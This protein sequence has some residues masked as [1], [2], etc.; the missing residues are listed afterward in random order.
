MKSI[1]MCC[2][3]N[4]SLTASMRKKNASLLRRVLDNCK[5]SQFGGSDLCD[6]LDNLPHIRSAFPQILGLRDLNELLRRIVSKEVLERSTLENRRAAELAQVFTPTSAYNNALVS[7]QRH[8]FVVLTG[9]P[10][11]GKTIIARIIG[12]AKLAEC[13]EC[14]ECRKPNDL[15]HMFNRSARQVFIAD[16]AFGSTEYRPDLALPWAD[17]LDRILRLLDEDHWLLWTSRPAPLHIALRHI[18]LKEL[19]GSF[20]D[21]G[22]V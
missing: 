13:W 2:L 21:P 7:L 20:P 5:I 1:T 15:F 10:E 22:E 8:H 6:Y 18:E 12:L 19:A 4:V 17:E 3:T 16:D 11:M 14:Y 9:P